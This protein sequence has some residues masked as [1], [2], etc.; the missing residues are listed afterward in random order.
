VGGAHHKL[1][2]LLCGTL[3]WHI[4]KG[5]ILIG[6]LVCMI[7]CETTGYVVKIESEG[8]YSG[9]AG[10]ESML[11]DNGY[12]V[13]RR[14]DIVWS[15]SPNNVVT[16]LD[17][18]FSREQVIRGA[19]PEVIKEYFE[20]RSPTRANWWVRINLFYTKDASKKVIRNIDAHVYNL[21]I[22]GISPEIKTE[23]DNICDLIYNTLSNE[24]GRENVTV[25]RKDWGP[26]VVF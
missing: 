18:R 16:S 6:L 13:G 3:M 9:I 5:F 25:E 19:S 21:Y 2:N 11:V 22:G 20:K 15:R 17:K 26:P 12:H 23:I 24:V 1:L 14:E 10:L 4:V 8:E 7:G